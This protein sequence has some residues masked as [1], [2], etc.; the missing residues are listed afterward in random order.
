[1]SATFDL[2]VLAAFAVVLRLQIVGVSLEVDRQAVVAQHLTGQDQ[3]L[4]FLSH[5]LNAAR[6]H[7]T[8]HGDKGERLATD[9]KVVLEP[10]AALLAA[11]LLHPVQVLG[12]EKGLRGPSAARLV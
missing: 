8:P 2:R 7:L 11:N 5:A 6:P 3:V 4:G 1:M 10:L 9:A 12:V